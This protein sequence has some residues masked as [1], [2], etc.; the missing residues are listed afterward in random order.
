MIKIALTGKL[1]S[2]KDTVAEHFVNSGFNAYKL[3][4]GITEII[5]RF[6][7]CD[8]KDGV[9][10][11][12]HYTT[13][14]QGLRQLDDE[15]WL[16]RTWSE[17]QRNNILFNY[18]NVIITDLRQKNEEEFLRDKGFIIVK[19][20][21][22]DF[23]RVE[24]AKKSDQ[25]FDVSQMYHETELS[26]DEIEADYTIGNEGTLEELTDKVNDLIVELLANGGKGIAAE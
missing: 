26:V 4:M 25:D 2:G 12:E 15:V 17:I 19:V 5:Q 16:K 7:P 23:L 20:E 6:F 10:L 18:K 21:A 22:A 1:R 8:L 3:S 13:I 11:R 9:K 14:G 24:R